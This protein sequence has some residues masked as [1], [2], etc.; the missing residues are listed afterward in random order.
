MYNHDYMTIVTQN[1]G[2]FILDVTGDQFGLEEW[3][4]TAMDYRSH[5]LLGILPSLQTE[6]EIIVGLE[7]EESR[8]P[9]LKNAVERAIA[10]EEAKWASRQLTWSGL[11][12][13]PVSDRDTLRR[14]MEATLYR[15]VQEYLEEA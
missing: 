7:G 9:G 6:A 11:P 13:L 12:G 10:S 8:L 15:E 3:F 4:Y 1:K 5:L 2:R 14:E